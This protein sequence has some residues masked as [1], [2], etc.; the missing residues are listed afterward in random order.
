MRRT[1]RRLW[2]I[3]P[4]YLVWAWVIA[5]IAAPILTVWVFG[6]LLPRL[7]AALG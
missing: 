7:W 2:W 4:A 3:V 6:D 1:I 5:P